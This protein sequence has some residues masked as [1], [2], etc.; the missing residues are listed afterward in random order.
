[1][2]NETTAAE[3]LPEILEAEWDHGQVM[4]LFDDLSRGAEVSHV[5]VR[6]NNSNRPQDQRATLDEA[7]EMFRDRAAKAIQIQYRFDGQAWCDTLMV[8]EHTTKIIRTRS[9]N[10][11]TG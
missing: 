4:A 11:G 6:S 1:M 9:T 2:I 5:Q 7:S 8:G 3:I 10:E